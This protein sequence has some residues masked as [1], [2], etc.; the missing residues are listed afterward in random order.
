MPD[1]S[2]AI[3]LLKKPIE[4]VFALATGAIKERIGVF[5]ANS[6]MQGLH[7]RL[8]ESQ[9]VKTIWHTDRPLSLSSFFHPVSIINES[10]NP[11]GEKLN[12]LDDLKNNHNVIFGTVGQGKSILLRYLLGKEIRSGTRIPILIELRNIGTQSLESYLCERFSLLLNIE[13]SDDIFNFFAS[14]GKITFL[15][16]GFDEIDADNVQKIMHDIEE[17][18]F[19][20]NSCRI[21]VTS[22]P[23][24]DCRHLTSFYVN[25]ITPLSADEL[26]AFYKR[27][28]R[29]QEF[30]DRL[31]AAIR[32]SPLKIRDLV[33]TPLLA[34]LL[35]ISYRAAHKIPL[36]FAEFYDE[37][38]QILLV[39]HDG[40]KL[41]WRRQRKTKLNDREIQQVFEAFC[42]ATRKRQ[43]LSFEKPL[44]YEI[45][46]QSLSEC[47]ITADPQGFLE[48]IKRI[49]CLLVDEGKKFNF[50][51][52]SVQEFFASRYIKTRAEPVAQKFYEQLVNGKWIS[53]QEELIF[54]FQIDSHRA[55]KYFKIP[56]IR[57]TLKDILGTKTSADKEVVEKYLKG[58]TV[59]KNMREGGQTPQY[60]VKRERNLHTY[61][62]MNL[63]SKVFNILFSLQNTALKSW[64]IGFVEDT[65]CTKRT[66]YQIAED[67]GGDTL[68]KIQEMLIKAITS[69][70]EELSKEIQ[71][72]SNEE[73]VTDFNKL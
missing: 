9:R 17:L 31:L 64:N 45:S 40:V 2:I 69:I 20:Y 5:R 14:N 6:K 24:S 25:K 63:D 33:N 12:S 22:R 10:T 53:W 67:R 13:K 41:G 62:Y 46:T 59:V 58:M 50:V 70:K 66:Y 1:F 68:N 72:V 52:A 19:K 15:L 16:D 32:V 35:A 47:K 29:D 65:N 26:P 28:T 44:A 23:D 38:F 21:V 3:A 43:A 55:T 27:I 51:H 73:A 30:T 48:D 49:T 4:E 18:S 56:D 39:R 8:W 37:L 61:Q 7:K 42:F 71:A 57:N 34:T 11:K 54:L 36:D 60:S